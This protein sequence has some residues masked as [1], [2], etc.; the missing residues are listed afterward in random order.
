[1]SQPLTL[2]CLYG[3]ATNMFLAFYS[4]PDSHR[5]SKGTG[6]AEYRITEHYQCV[7]SLR[8]AK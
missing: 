3:G 1:M 8:H 6:Q 5:L 2:H 7:N 4:L